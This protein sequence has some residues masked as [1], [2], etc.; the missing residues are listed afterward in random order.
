MD[1]TQPDLR[2]IIPIVYTPFDAEGGIDFAPSPAL[3]LS[4]TAFDNRVRDAIAN[5]TIGRN[6]R[7]RRNIAAIEARGIEAGARMELGEV[8]LGGS[9]AYTD[10]AMRGGAGAPALEGRRPAQ[11]PRWSASGT[12]SW[13]PASDWLLS[14]TV[15]HVGAQ[16]EDDL[17]MDVLPAVTT[18]DAYAQVPLGGSAALVLR[19]DNLTDAAVITRNQGGSIDLGAPR[20]IWIGVQFRK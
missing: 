3:T 11:T 2:G 19:A 7:Q 17:G 6:L 18:T 9:L 8:R 12:V 5:V 20:T 10:A 16:F 14:L 13:R 4:V 1:Q 15:R